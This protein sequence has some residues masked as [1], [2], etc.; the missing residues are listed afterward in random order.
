MRACSTC[1]PWPACSARLLEGKA[2]QLFTGQ[3]NNADT[4]LR[5]S[6]WRHLAQLAEQR[7]DADAAAHVGNRPRCNAVV[8]ARPR[9]RR[10]RNHPSDALAHYD[11]VPRVAQPCT[12]AW[13]WALRTN[14]HSFQMDFMI[15]AVRHNTVPWPWH[16]VS[17]QPM[18]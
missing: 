1:R 12:N 2:Q 14:K 16:F 15:A 10:P 4:P 3:R 5:A 9:R 8:A 13:A 11:A 17:H 7:A 18:G 6:A